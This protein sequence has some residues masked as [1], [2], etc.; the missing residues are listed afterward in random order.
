M[1]PAPRILARNWRKHCNACLGCQRISQQRLRILKTK[2]LSNRKGGKRVSHTTA[3]FGML[4]TNPPCK[5]TTYNRK[6]F[7]QGS[8]PRSRAKKEP[9]PGSRGKRDRSVGE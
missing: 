1:R 4:S 7:T 2:Y 6:K 3:L 9:W 5:S 8:N